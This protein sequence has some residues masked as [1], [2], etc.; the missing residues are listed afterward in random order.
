VYTIS[1]QI[2]SNI[3]ALNLSYL[4]TIR[5]YQLDETDFVLCTKL[6]HRGSNSGK[7]G[8]VG[9]YSCNFG[10]HPCKRLKHSNREVSYCNIAHRVV[11]KQLMVNLWRKWGWWKQ[12]QYILYGEN[13]FWGSP[14]YSYMWAFWRAYEWHWLFASFYVSSFYGNISNFT[15]FAFKIVIFWFHFSVW[16]FQCVIL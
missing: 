9:N 4:F 10:T 1:V 3:L 8:L 11:K 2:F 7:G 15:S 12:Q 5:S 16:S 13:L 6:C 14:L